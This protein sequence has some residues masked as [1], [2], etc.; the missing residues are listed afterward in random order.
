MNAT[1]EQPADFVAGHD[2]PSPVTH[3]IGFGYSDGVTDGIL[4]TR[5][6]SVYR[7]HLVDEDHNPDGLDRRTFRLARLPATAF[8]DIVALLS[9][10]VDA[11][12]PCWVPLWEFPS[13]DV[14]R[15]VDE[16]I[17]GWLDAAGP[18]AWLV[19]AQDLLDTIASY[20]LLVTGA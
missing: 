10:F 7:F 12:W 5:G 11:R 16:K 20:P 8:T 1:T 2:Y 14:R 3:V 18:D 19:K 4:K 6:G 17:E 15:S 9:P 13:D